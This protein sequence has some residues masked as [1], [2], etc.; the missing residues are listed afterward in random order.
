[1]VFMMTVA[2]ALLAGFFIV[3]LTTA[4]MIGSIALLAD[5]GH[6]LTD[7]AATGLDENPVAAGQIAWRG[8]RGNV[9]T[10]IWER[11]GS[12]RGGVTAA[13]IPNPVSRTAAWCG[14]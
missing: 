3:E 5:A 12:E 4:L 9:N 2:T 8:R 6:I 14:A 13:N 7:V 1:M 11:V 10:R